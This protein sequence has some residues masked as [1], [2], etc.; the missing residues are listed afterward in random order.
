MNTDD[1][2]GSRIIEAIKQSGVEYVLAVPDITT[3]A[4]LLWP[5]ASDSDLR[6]IRVCREAETIGISAG[7]SYRDIRAVTMFQNTGFLESINAI[8]AV[9]VEYKMP[10]CMVVGLLNKEPNVEPTQ[11]RSYGVRIVEPIL[12]AMGIHYQ[13]IESDEDIPKIG[14]VVE[15]C[16]TTPEPGAILIG[17]SVAP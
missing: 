2:S 8:R 6:L 12:E 1:L 9:A 7:L 16:Y 3:S 10:I 5:I 11:S 17:R 15:R 4:G 13:L 14:P